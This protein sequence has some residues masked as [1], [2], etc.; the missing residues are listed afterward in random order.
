[1]R[2]EARVRGRRPSGAA[3][4]SIGL[5]LAFGAVSCAHPIAVRGPGSQRPSATATDD[6]CAPVAARQ[7]ALWST[8]PRVEE[9][10]LVPE[11]FSRCVRTPHGAWSL[12]VD[13][14]RREPQH[15][16]LGHW[17]LAHY[18]ARG[19]RVAVALSQPGDAAF[20]DLTT[21]PDNL[22]IDPPYRGLLVEQ[23]AFDYDGDGEPE[24]A[25]TLQHIRHEDSS[26]ARGRVWT[27]RDGHITLY[28]PARAVDVARVDDVD[29]DGRPDLL[30]VAPFTRI[31]VARG[32]GFSSRVVGPE[33]VFHSLASGEFSSVDAVAVRA[34]RVA[35]PDAPGPALRTAVEVACA[36]ARGL[37]PRDVDAAI[38]R[39]CP[40]VAD[41][42]D[43]D[44]CPER[45]AMAEFARLSSPTPMTR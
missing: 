21:A 31:A 25:L 29:A 13:A 28:A 26:P 41:D 14:L 9:G 43:D 8:L 44:P 42:A 24:L 1:M 23:A 15:M 35:C 38:Q 30:S 19:G 10:E 16:W 20:D 17:S 12:E 33:W 40:P 34:A 2:G 32:S 18:D 7:R 39:G 22:D 4:A 27:F 45:T 3:R 6:P 36:R 11:N 5:W 37:S